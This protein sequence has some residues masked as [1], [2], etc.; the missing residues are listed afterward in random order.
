MFVT[1]L[2][3]STF[4]AATLTIKTFSR[5]TLS[6]TIKNMTLHNNCLIMTLYAECPVFIAML[7][8]GMLCV[9][10]LNVAMLK[11]LWHAIFTLTVTKNIFLC[12]KFYQLDVAP[13]MYD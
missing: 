4:S 1:I 6:I 10:M 5:A 3:S 7:N 12:S 9:I 2:L 8:I 13:S 11:V